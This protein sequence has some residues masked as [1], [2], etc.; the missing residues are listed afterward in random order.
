MPPSCRYSGQWPI[1]RT[2]ALGAFP[3]GIFT[4]YLLP[5]SLYSD[6]HI[7]IWCWCQRL[8]RHSRFMTMVWDIFV[9][10]Q[11]QKQRYV[12]F[13][14]DDNSALI[15]KAFMYLRQHMHIG[16]DFGAFELLV[17][18]AIHACGA[19][20]LVR[21][22]FRAVSLQKYHWLWTRFSWLHAWPRVSFEY[23]SPSNKCLGYTAQ[24]R[25]DAYDYHIGKLSRV[26]PTHSSGRRHAGPAKPTLSHLIPY[27]TVGLG[28]ISPI[29][30]A[31]AAF[32]RRWCRTT[33]HWCR[34]A[35]TKYGILA[36]TYPA[37]VQGDFDYWS[38]DDN[39]SLW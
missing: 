18:F 6:H 31:M 23:G 35:I 14:T 30:H 24:C 32:Y 12:L 3:R 8:C 38:F 27:K 33:R 16:W 25:Y 5:F 34:R 2:Y 36:E 11:R 20:A 13:N 39:I 10:C 28:R 37:P 26:L 7:Q 15:G 22:G 9:T 1:I 19:W 29:R 17:W 21:T 4:Q